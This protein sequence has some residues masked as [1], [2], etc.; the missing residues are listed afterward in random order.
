MRVFRDGLRAFLAADVRRQL[1]HVG[2]WG[3]GD[4][5]DVR[6]TADG[7]AI[8]HWRHGS[9]ELGVSLVVEGLGIEPDRSRGTSV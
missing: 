5:V 9:E 1:R 6:V 7:H 3:E 2:I 4:R 8:I